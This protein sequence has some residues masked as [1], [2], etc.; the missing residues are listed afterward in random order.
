MLSCDTGGVPGGGV[1]G[2]LEALQSAES[3][4]GLAM[5]KHLGRGP[6]G[7]RHGAKSTPESGSLVLVGVLLGAGEGLSTNR[8]WRLLGVMEMCCILTEYPAYKFF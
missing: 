1:G 8:F 4:R 6:E 3:N 7:R 5:H 2:C